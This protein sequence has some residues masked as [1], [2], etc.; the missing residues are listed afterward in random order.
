M[1]KVFL[2]HEGAQHCSCIKRLICSG[3]ALSKEVR[4]RVSQLLPSVQLENLYGPTE[5]AID[6]TRWFCRNDGSDVIP[7]GRPIWNTRVYVLDGGLQPVPVGVAGELYIAGA[8]LARGYLDRAGL[9]AERFVA[10]PFGACGKPDVPQRGSGA[11]ACGRGA[12]LSRA[13][14][15]AGE[16][17][18]LPH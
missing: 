13:R 17:A 11:L 3:E 15:C 14:G 18:R 5:A 6:V 9:T 4:D 12:G 2:A 8:G 16:A 1:L 7:I 10:D